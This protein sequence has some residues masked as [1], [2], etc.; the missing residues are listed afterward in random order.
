MCLGFF[1]TSVIYTVPRQLL[2]LRQ[3]HRRK[4]QVNQLQPF[5]TVIKTENAWADKVLFGKSERKRSPEGP[6]CNWEANI[7]I[8]D[9]E[10]RYRNVVW[11]KLAIT[12][13]FQA[14][15]AVLLWCG[16]FVSMCKHIKNRR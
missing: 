3:I 12:A 7:K 1:T 11:I 9:T 5:L 6:T 4:L 14:S 10:I 15:V 2:F 16:L 8:N 13:F